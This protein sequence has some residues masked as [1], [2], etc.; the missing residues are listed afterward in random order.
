MTTLLI[1]AMIGLRSA[2]IGQDN[3]SLNGSPDTGVPEVYFYHGMVLDENLREIEP[4]LDNVS[5]VLRRF[6]EALAARA[7]ETTNARMVE[8]LRNAPIPR[9]DKYD[10]LLRS[11]ALAR[12][13][14]Q[15]DS[16]PQKESLDPMLRALESWATIPTRE[17]IDDQLRNNGRLAPLLAAMEL[18]PKDEE[19]RDEAPTTTPYI[20]K[21]RSEQVPIPPNFGDPKWVFQGRLDPNFSFVA[22]E[23]GSSGSVAEVW[24]F[25]DP[26]VPGLCVGLPRIN[27]ATGGI[28]LFGIICQSAT[29]GKACFWDNKD[30][31]LNLLSPEAS[32]RLK[33]AEVADGS[34]LGENCTNCHRGKNV[35]VIHP[36]Q[37]VDVRDEFETDHGAEWYEPISG[38]PSWG[39]PRPIEGLT[40]CNGCHEMPEVRENNNSPAPLGRISAF[41]RILRQ[42]VDKT[43]PPDGQPA[44]WVHPQS[45]RADVELLRGKCD[46]F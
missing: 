46:Q 25:A 32:K 2:A 45:H 40:E 15:N 43:M 3:F 31:E 36:R 37:A 30:R 34:I 20:E 10:E 42:V 6:S 22:E 7:P 27:N 16:S 29:T 9:M 41:C 17:G 19:V 12:W 33:I 8:N 13:L 18:K 44:G 5:F 26:N 28:G 1:G 11:V 24:T 39:N 35:F 23:P 14:L 4:T 21:C 38:Q